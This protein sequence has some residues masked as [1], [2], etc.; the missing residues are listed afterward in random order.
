VPAAP[1]DFKSALEDFEKQL[2]LNAL[3]RHCWHREKAA[4]S[5]QIPRRTFFRKLKKLG[6]ET[7]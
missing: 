5:L 2:I 3:E 7:A 6:I 1:Q 4:Q